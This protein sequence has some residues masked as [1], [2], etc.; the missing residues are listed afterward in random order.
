[1]MLFSFVLKAAA[2]AEVKEEDAKEEENVSVCEPV[3]EDGDD[4]AK[5]EQK[6]KED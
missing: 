2:A 6:I 1:M 5:R 3:E 4:D